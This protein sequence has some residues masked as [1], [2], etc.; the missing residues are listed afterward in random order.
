MVITR[1]ES[2]LYVK[3]NMARRSHLIIILLQRCVTFTCL[4]SVHSGE[5]YTYFISN[6]CS[7]HFTRVRK[8]MKRPFVCVAVKF[9]GAAT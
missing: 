4:S 1:L 7:L 2:I 9:A 3:F 5:Y 6:N 8:N